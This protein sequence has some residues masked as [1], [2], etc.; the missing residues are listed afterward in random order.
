AIGGISHVLEHMMFQGTER[1][2]PNEFSRIIAEEG[3]RENAFTSYD[4]TGY[5]QLLERSRLPIAFELE[6]ERM[7]NLRLRQQEFEK[8]VQVVMEERRLRTEDRPESLVYERFAREAY[9]VH[10]YG[11]PIIGTFDSLERMTLDDLR[12]WYHLFY[13]PN[14]AAVVV[15]G[16][17]EAEEVR[18]E[19]HTSEL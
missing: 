12:D 13:R 2:E 4:Y 5:F 9:R 15:V 1:L 17:V 11:Q 19:E 18:S 3:G 10:P 14:N 7:A 6:A 8:E 16:D